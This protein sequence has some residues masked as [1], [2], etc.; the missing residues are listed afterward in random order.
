MKCFDD[1]YSMA[2]IEKTKKFLRKFW[3][4]EEKLAFSVYPITPVNYRK[5]ESD[6]ETIIL[7]AENILSGG[8]LPGFNV[9][10]YVA[11]LGPESM[12][13]FWGGK[14]YTY[15]PGKQGIEPVIFSADDVSKIAAKHLPYNEGDTARVI[16]I[17]RSISERLGTDDLECSTLDIQGPLNTASLLWQQEDFMM[18]MYDYPAKVHELLEHVTEF[19]IELI[20]EML[21]KTEGKNS[22][23]MWPYIWLPPDMGIGITE[24]YMPL[25][26]ADLYKEFGLPYVERLG[27]EFGGL[28]IHCCGKFNQHFYNLSHA[29]MN[30]LGI[31]YLY[32]YM[33]PDVLYNH[34]GSSVAFVNTQSNIGKYEFPLLIDFIK[35]VSTG[36]LKNMKKYFVLQDIVEE[37][38]YEQ[39]RYIEDLI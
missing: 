33:T 27:K 24:D 29:D 17:W 31:E 14:R 11:D 23:P 3:Y 8:N 34:F 28:F 4:G 32:P 5:L 1:V 16:K 6:E 19:L 39:I 25:L 20:H 26:S 10:R 7:A 12:P 36:K 21:D 30:I 2:K 15:T 13:S 9:P 22:G 35:Y 18:S 37:D 38:V